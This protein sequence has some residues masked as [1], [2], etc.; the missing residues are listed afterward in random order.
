MSLR[1]VHYNE[2]VLR[3]KGEK[4]IAFNGALADLAE[5]MI[6]TMHEAGGIGLAAPQVG[7]SSQLC[8][9]DLREVD[10][11]FF[12]ELDGGRPPLELFMPLVL[13]NPAISIAAGTP[14][15]AA[16]EGCL[17]FPQIRGEIPRPAAIA[18]KFLDQ[19]RVPHQLACDGLLARCIQHEVD[20]L[21]GVLFIDRMDKSTRA[22]LDDA[23]KALARATRAARQT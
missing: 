8:V 21:N 9:V 19:H 7:R 3:T 16:E 12:W 18:V 2:P 23:I 4:V 1:I 20:H 13:V 17:S 6:A 22:K 10:A 5:E 14:E 11:R 15:V